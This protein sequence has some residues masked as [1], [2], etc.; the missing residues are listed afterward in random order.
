MPWMV[1]LL[2]RSVNLNSAK[3][4]TSLLFSN[5]KLAGGRPVALSESFSVTKPE[6]SEVLRN[7]WNWLLSASP[8]CTSKAH[9]VWKHME[10]RALPPVQHTVTVSG[11]CFVKAVTS[12]SIIH[13]LIHSRCCWSS[14]SLCFCI[15]FLWLMEL[16]AYKPQYSVV[17]EQLSLRGILMSNG[18]KV[19]IPSPV[20]LGKGEKK[21][22]NGVIMS[23]NKSKGSACSFKV[24]KDNFFILLATLKIGQ[25]HP[26]MPQTKLNRRC[27]NFTQI[28][29]CLRQNFERYYLSE[30][31]FFLCQSRKWFTSE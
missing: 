30:K 11:P 19:A 1:C 16:C 6:H 5:H 2:K 18:D 12:A 8:D 15:S 21:K 10:R 9:T 27:Q 13:Q 26:N 24:G 14:T 20:C 23:H 29:T 28:Y 7:M 4:H 3:C 22:K 17:K 31:G 25:G